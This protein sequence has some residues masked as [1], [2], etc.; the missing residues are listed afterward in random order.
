[1]VVLVPPLR[2]SAHVLNEIKTNGIG[3]NLITLC[4]N[5]DEPGMKMTNGQKAIS[6]GHAYS[7]VNVDDENVY[8]VNPW[9]SSEIIT[10]PLEKFNK[11]VHQL[12]QTVL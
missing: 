12:Y 6:D 7:L 4:F 11:N 2:S 8:L 9:D 1:M 10:Y 5:Y 3:N